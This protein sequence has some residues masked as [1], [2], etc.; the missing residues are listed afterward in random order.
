MSKTGAQEKTKVYALLEMMT[1]LLGYIV[2]LCSILLHTYLLQ[3]AST[4]LEVCTIVPVKAKCN[5]P[6]I[7][8]TLLLLKLNISPT[9]YLHSQFIQK[10]TTA[11]YN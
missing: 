4:I 11:I 3:N 5:T 8:T 6:N 1:V 10:N 9:K 2:I 7:T